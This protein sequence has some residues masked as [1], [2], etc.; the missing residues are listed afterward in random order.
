MLTDELLKR[1]EG[2]SNGS[3]K[4]YP[5]R[6][7]YRLMYTPELW[8]VA[9]S[10]LKN[11]KGAITQ[12][13]D[14]D[15]LDGFS[16]LRVDAIIQQLKEGTYTPKPV[17]RTY[18]P[19]SNGK[20]RPLG[21]PSGT[22]K[23]VQE[24]ARTILERVYE[25]VFSNCS[26]GFR[27]KR[28]CHTALATIQNT[29][30]GTKWICDVDIKG[31]F[32]NISHKLMVEF[33]KKRIDDRRF[34]SLIEQMLKAG[35]LENWKYVGTYSG[36]P[37]GGIISPI[38]SNIYLDELDKY[39]EK[40]Q[41]QFN[42]GE[43]KGKNLEYYQRINKIYRHRKRIDLIKDNPAFAEEVNERKRA[44]AEHMET[45]QCMPSTDTHDPSFKRLRYLRYADD[46]VIGIIGSKEEAQN[47]MSVVKR[48]IETEL[49]LSI[50]EEKT[51][52]VSMHDGFRFLNYEIDYHSGAKIVKGKIHGRHTKR[53]TLEQVVRLSAPKDKIRQFCKTHGYG[54]YDEMTS[55]HRNKLLALSVPEIILTYNAELRG[56]TNYYSLDRLVKPRMSKLMYIANHS[57][58]KTMANKL[59]MGSISKV[60]KMMQR[61]NGEFI[62][63]EKGSK[64][65][66]QFTV[67]RTKHIKKTSRAA[68][69][70][71]LDRLDYMPNTL[72]ITTARTEVL[73]RLEAN[74]CEHCGSNDKCEVHHV[75]KLKDLKAKRNKSFY[76]Q[77]MI[78]RNRKTMVLCE[79]CHHDLH[80]GKLNLKNT[81]ESEAVVES[82]VP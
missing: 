80:N 58:Y 65:E 42:M 72:V 23:L 61:S 9:Y 77:M 12:G 31:F 49:N 11:N 69:Q 24:V 62:W 71:R 21:I 70:N 40:L 13:V 36:A 33:L 4:G 55:T 47:I 56:F 17:R 53:R 63:V 46:F 19:K 52:M 3:V 10:H 1:L 48:F 68:N 45:M 27:P 74:E 73:K 29:W 20:T 41:Y 79:R 38:L 16:K 35:Y 54:N 66:H 60:T 6:N 32:D 64:K 14:E 59:K 8:M 25:P 76:D 57:L 26:H 7:L 28:S 51:N 30:N 44:I 39:I 50:N 75:R 15:T 5:I 18:I 81:V 67:F 22:D 78:A 2:I 82:R 37:Q 34:L 43:E